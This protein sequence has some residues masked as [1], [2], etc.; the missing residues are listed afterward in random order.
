MRE[1]IA[2]I[3]FTLLSASASAVQPEPDAV[4]Q[5]QTVAQRWLTLVDSA[6]Y[7]SSWDEAAQP[8]R[9]AISQSDWQTAITSAR[10][11]L[12]PLEKRALISATYTEQ[13]PGAPAGQYVLIQYQ[14]QFANK[15]AA[16]ETVTPSKDADGVWRVSGYFVK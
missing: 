1:I 8:F 10:S 7:A 5:A 14:T 16:I 11:P 4:Q 13:L 9:T 12:G 6:Q 2:S 3:F 15:K